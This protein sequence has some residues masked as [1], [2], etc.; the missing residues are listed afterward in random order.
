MLE[1]YKDK[2]LLP[3]ISGGNYFT[4]LKSRKHN[5]PQRSYKK[6]YQSYE[7]QAPLV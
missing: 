4:P 5:S 2:D 1:S 3:L 7:K 6:T